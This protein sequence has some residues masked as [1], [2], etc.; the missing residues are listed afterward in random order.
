MP[1]NLEFI[2]SASTSST[3]IFTVTDCFNANYDIYKIYISHFDQVTYNTYTNMRLVDS[4][5]NVI[6]DNEY[7]R[8]E[9][10]LAAYSSFEERKNE[11]DDELFT[12]LNF[13]QGAALG[14]GLVIMVYN[15]FSSSHF[16]RVTNH[17]VGFAETVSSIGF[18]GVGIHKVQESITGV[19]FHM[20]AGNID[21]AEI[22]VY[23]VT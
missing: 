2:K 11:P 10:Q 20:D 17:S 15:P 6:S 22:V 18:R 16:T 19:S 8:G 9:Q 3:S 13:N 12:R 7:G 5:G 21:S 14:V 4:G 23:G 1:T